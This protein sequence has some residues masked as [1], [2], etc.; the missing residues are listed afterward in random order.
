MRLFLAL[1][2]S[3]ESRAD[4]TRVLETFSRSLTGWRFVEPGAIH[5]TLRFLGELQPE[6]ERAHRDAWRTTVGGFAPIRFRLGGAGVFPDPAR[7]RVLWIGVQEDP[8]G[9]KLEELAR[10]LE[11]AA[12]AGGFP[13]ED[14]PF[15]PHLT[16]ARGRKDVRASPPRETLA[17]LGSVVECAEVALLRSELGPA[18]ARY[19][20]LDAFPLAGGAGPR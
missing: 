8:P 20:R 14:R 15:H 9:G 18:G 1:E 11:G 6:R 17:E 7:P 3:E 5:L 16:L 13:P 19:S 10:A 2:L 4:L 12:R